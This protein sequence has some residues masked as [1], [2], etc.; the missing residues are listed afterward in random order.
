MFDSSTSCLAGIMF[1][2]T[3]NAHSESAMNTASGQM[4]VLADTW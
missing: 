3:E 1:S 2:L 4:T